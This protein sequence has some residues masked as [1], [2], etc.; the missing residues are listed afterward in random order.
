MKKGGIVR[1]SRTLYRRRRKLSFAKRC[2]RKQQG[3][4]A[5]YQ[6]LSIA[7]KSTL[8]LGGPDGMRLS[9]E[10]RRPREDGNDGDEAAY[11]GKE[12]GYD[13]TLKMFCDP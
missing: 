12:R 5:R 11:M 2:A 9:P 7:S 6:S 4:V 8:A 10:N 13:P 3:G 1:S